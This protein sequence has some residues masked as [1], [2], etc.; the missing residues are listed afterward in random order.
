MYGGDPGFAFEYGGSWADWHDQ[1]RNTMPVEQYIQT[2]LPKARLPF[3]EMQSGG[4]IGYAEGKSYESWLNYRLKEIAKGNLPVPFKEWQKGDIKMASGG[5]AY[6][7]GEP[8]YSV[9]GSVGHAPWHKPTAQQQPQQ[10]LDTPTPNVATRPDPLKAPRGIPSVAPKN[11]DPAYMQQQM[12]QQAMMGRGNTGQGPRPMAKE[13]GIMRMGFKK[14]GDMSRRGFMKLIAGLAA[15]PVVGKYFKLA[16]PAAKVAETFTHV[17]IKDIPGMPVWFKPLVAKVIK[18]GTDVTKKYAVKDMEVVHHA[19]LPGSGTDVI[20]T[21]QLDTGDVL[22][23]IGLGKHGW[24]AGRYGQPARLEYKAAEDIMTGPSDEPFKSG[25]KRDP[26]LKIKTEVH[27]DLVG[28]G[29]KG[30][31]KS[32]HLKPGKT[33]EEFFV[34]EAEFT[35]GHPENVKF[36][37][38]VAEKYGDHASDFTEVE[39]YATGK[40]IDKKIIG[41]KAAR[42]D[43][44]E[45]RAMEQAED[46]D[47]AKGGLAY[48][49]G[50]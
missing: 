8:T 48:L 43:W 29:L 18:E 49:L 36:E 11:M 31:P 15:L 14:G 23:D 44:A 50:E 38:S 3:R 17:P 35:G 39:K 45:G 22:V 13:G 46:V 40:N 10:Q 25:M 4:R 37:E 12:M 16:K 33:K 5:L 47:F 28:S 24:S 32:L 1:H 7:L 20:V 21:Q 41:K 34:D 27:E 9:G 19:K 26:F 6:M 42:D 2:K 30:D